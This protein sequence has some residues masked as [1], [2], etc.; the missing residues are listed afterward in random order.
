MKRSA[1][2][3]DRTKNTFKRFFDEN[4]LTK[5]KIDYILQKLNPDQLKTFKSELE[6]Y[7]Q[8]LNYSNPTLFKKKDSNSTNI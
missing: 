7:M 2:N 4:R 1:V 8:K 5:E 6:G 3:I